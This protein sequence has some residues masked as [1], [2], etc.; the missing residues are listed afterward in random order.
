MCDSFICLERVYSIVCF[1]YFSAA[2]SNAHLPVL[3][4]N[5]AILKKST[6]VSFQ[7]WI[8]SPLL[9]DIE[10][11]MMKTCLFTYYR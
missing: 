2:H 4:L 3:T 5:E 1:V 7:G 10:F 9:V 11:V 8:S 6:T